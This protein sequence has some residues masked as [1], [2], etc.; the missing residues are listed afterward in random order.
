MTHDFGLHLT[1]ELAKRFGLPADTWPQST[2]QVAPFFTIVVNALGPDAATR[3]FEAA[4]RAHQKVAAADR[5]RTHQFGF[6]MHLDVEAEA[7][8]ETTLSIVAAFEATKALYEVTRRDP[9]ADVDTYF[10]CALRACAG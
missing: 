5:D 1:Q 6:P 3:W 7:H 10:D 2:E 9:T 4:R 8:K